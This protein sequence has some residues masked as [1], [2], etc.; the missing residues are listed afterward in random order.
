M[1]GFG[2]I[3][4]TIAVLVGGFIGLVLKKG[5]SD[6][7]RN[8][9]E[10]AIGVSVMFLGLSGA[11][12]KML[13]L[14]PDGSITVQGTMMATVSMVLGAVIGEAIDIDE[15][16]N[17]IGLSI[18]KHIGKQNDSQFVEGFVSASLIICV[19]AMAILGPLRDALEHDPTMLYTKSILDATILVIYTSAYGV[20]AIFSAVSVFVYQG[21]VTLLAGLIAPVLSPAI[22]NSI[23]LVGSILIFCLGTTQF[24]KIKIKVANFLPAILI[25]CL[26]TAFIPH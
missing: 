23:S 11:L 10:Q 2:T 5:V 22:I 26:Y 1:I 24:L 12:S 3:V 6:R 7:F 21:T 19:G 17:R 14:L 4:N 18:R 20:G 9:I 16:F 25:A 8:I 15:K 13:I